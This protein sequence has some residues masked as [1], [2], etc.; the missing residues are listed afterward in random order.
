MS[1][2][3]PPTLGEKG[4]TATFVLAK[5]E[6]EGEGVKNKHADDFTAFVASCDAEKGLAESAVAGLRAKFGFNEL[7]EKKRSPLLMCVLMTRG[8]GCRRRRRRRA[9]SWVGWTAAP[10]P[11]HATASLPA[12][13]ASSLQ[14]SVFFLGPHA[15]H[16]LGRHYHR[17]GAGH[18]LWR[19]LGRLWCDYFAEGGGRGG[20]GATLRL[21]RHTH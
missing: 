2:D 4:R 17:A 20:G 6:G 7:P 14:V 9:R 15:V 12:F 19:G 21:R 16:D 5:A 11:R 1:A 18:H 3:A 10:A 8:R 13:S